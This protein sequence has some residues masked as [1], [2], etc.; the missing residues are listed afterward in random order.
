MRWPTL[1]LLGIVVAVLAWWLL[2]GSRGG[3]ETTVSPADAVASSGGADLATG[4]VPAVSDADAAAAPTARTRLEALAVA[5]EFGALAVR[6]VAAPD[7]VALAHVAVHVSAHDGRDVASTRRTRVTGAAGTAL[8][9][10]LDAGPWGVRTDRSIGAQEETVVEVEARAQTELIVRV[11]SGLHAR[12]RVVD[13][14]RAVVPGA[15]V[16]HWPA[17]HQLDVP[18][19]EP[20]E[21]IGTTDARGELEVQALVHFAGHGSWFVARHPAHG[22]SVARMVRSPSEESDREIRLVVLALD[23]AGARIEL[24]V[25]DAQAQALVGAV[26]SARPLDRA[27]SADD[28]QSRVLPQAV[29]REVTGADGIARLTPL[30]AGDYLVRVRAAGHAPYEEWVHV[31]GEAVLTRDVR[32][33]AAARVHGTVADPAGVPVASA[34]VQIQLEG[35]GGTTRTGKD[36]RFAVDQLPAGS[37]DWVAMHPEHRRAAGPIVLVAGD[38]QVIAIELQRLPDLHGRVIDESGAGLAAWS[39]VAEAKQPGGADD[40]RRSATAADGSFRMVARPDIDYALGVVEPGQVFAAPIPDLGPVR[41]RQEPWLVTVPDAARATAFVEG[42]LVD[43]SGTPAIAG[44]KLSLQR[45]GPA[46]AWLGHTAPLPEVDAASGWF[47]VGPVSA[48]TYWLWF[49][50]PQRVTFPLRDLTLRPRQTTNLG[51]IEEPAMGTLAVVLTAES[52]CQVGDVRVQL[53]ADGSTDIV[54]VDRRSLRAQRDLL[55]RTYS[56]TV[57]G[58]GFRSFSEDLVIAAGATTELRGTLRAAVRVILR[59]HMP[60]GE[61]GATFEVRDARGALAFDTELEKGLAFTDWYPHL[62][63]GRFDV[64]ARGASGKAYFGAFTVESLV[65]SVEPIEVRVEPMR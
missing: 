37:G 40:Q 51:R 53:E 45:D 25:R 47:R 21:A 13:A 3:P 60:A 16:L 58:T 8:F 62:D 63:R 41:P 19:S 12:I 56:A 31:T 65:R 27:S 49:W 17:H 39:V 32:L 26:A 64:L 61:Q 33:A 28:D 54:P 48:G 46:R 7:D 57:Y 36:G 15:E 9:E 4:G 22:T 42:F 6:V 5:H 34:V 55:P 20:G 24:L 10:D 50:S 18:G 38:D 43:R 1:A 59:F 29:R 14:G 52:E 30:M 44:K 2:D 35:G 23:P 11:P